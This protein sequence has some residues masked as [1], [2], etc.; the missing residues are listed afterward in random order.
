MGPRPWSLY[1]AV[2]LSQKAPNALAG[3][4]EV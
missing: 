2:R 3:I 4:T 1:D